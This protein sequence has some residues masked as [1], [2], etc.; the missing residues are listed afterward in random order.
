MRNSIYSITLDEAISAVGGHHTY[1][2]RAL[3]VICLLCF[4]V[5]TS[6]F[7]VDFMTAEPKLTCAGGSCGSV[8]P[9][10]APNFE[11]SDD[12]PK[13]PATEWRLLCSESLFVHMLNWV[14]CGSLALGALFFSCVERS[15][16]RKRTMHWSSGLGLIAGACVCGSPY[17][18]TL[19]GSMALKGI[20]DAGVGLT[21]AISVVE[22]TDGGFRSWFVGAGMGAGTLGYF[23]GYGTGLLLPHWRV[24]AMLP[25]ILFVLSQP[26]FRFLL[27][28]PRYLAAIKGKYPSSRNVLQLIS[29]T[30][31]HPHFNDML[32]G[33]KV[34]GYQE[35]DKPQTLVDTNSSSS[36]D[37]AGKLVFVPITNGIVSVSQG[38]TKSMKRFYH[39]DLVRLEST[40]GVFLICGLGWMSVTI[41]LCALT[42]LPG[43][44]QWLVVLSMT[45]SDLLSILITAAIVNKMGRLSVNITYMAICG[46]CC[47]LTI[48]FISPNCHPE[49]LCRINEVMRGLMLHS[50]RLFAKAELFLLC[51]YTLELFPTVVRFPG[52]SLCVCLSAAVYFAWAVLSFFVY[53]DLI[54]VLLISGIACLLLSIL[55]CVLPDSSIE[56]L[57][58]YVAEEVEEMKKPAELSQVE[59]QPSASSE[60]SRRLQLK[61]Q[62]F[63][64][65][66]EEKP[67]SLNV[68]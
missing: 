55:A 24:V 47:V 44:G 41:T 29:S 17:F 51:L 14:Y 50:A 56:E 34:I 36:R 21:A 2:K 6:V 40:R 20:A 23:A 3:C 11:V 37:V 31:R 39:W 13:T 8:K 26:L 45:L 18:Y 65:M 61:D 27:E 66:N 59:I 60:T 15:I 12:S 19:Y 9:C 25:P 48:A 58:D 32:E 22:M 42:S 52:L 16:G 64:V 33:E 38:D 1:Q 49:G 28:S 63:Q 68:P 4:T 10:D 62:P 35:T 5:G 57:L 67:G 53:V 30:N 46:L 43:T 7:A 54:P